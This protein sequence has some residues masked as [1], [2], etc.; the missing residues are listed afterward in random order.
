MIPQPVRTLYSRPCAQV[1]VYE[2]PGNVSEAAGTSV[3]LSPNGSATAAIAREH[4]RAIGKSESS[5]AWARGR[6]ADTDNGKPNFSRSN[7]F[8]GMQKGARRH[9]AYGKR[10]DRVWGGGQGKENGNGGQL[11]NRR[12]T[13]TMAAETQGRNK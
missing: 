3:N 12:D 8:I 11:R 2:D 6:D 4:C 13:V 9:V 5:L 1:L 7:S 10:V